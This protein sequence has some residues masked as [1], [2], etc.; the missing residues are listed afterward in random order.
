LKLAVSGHPHL[1]YCTNIHAGETW[2][3][4]RANLERYV[5]AVKA[6]VAPD[7]P[8]G[9]GLRLSARAA[10][11]LAEPAELEALRDFL[12]THGLYVFTINGFPY[13]AFH[14]TRVKEDVYRPDWLEE[15]RVAYTDRLATLL[16]QLLPAQPGLEGSVSTAPGAFKPRVKGDAD[17]ARMADLIIRHVV[18]LHAIR[19]KTG[20]SI[21]LALEP[22]PHCY[23]ET[24]AETVAF[25][26]DYL[27]ASSA[28]ARLSDVIGL[29]RGESEAVL[30]RHLGVCFDACHMAVEFEHPGE[31]LRA[32]QAA[33]IRIGKVQISAGLRVLFEGR[34]PERLAALR[35]FAEGVYL[36]QVV[37]QRG[38][39]LSRYLDLPQALA[40]ADPAAADPREWRVHF[41]VPLF[42]ERLGL[43]LNTQDYLRALLGILRKDVVSQHLEVETYTWDVLPEAYRREDIVTA[44]TRELEWVLERMVSS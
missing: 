8:F 44:V 20:K 9:V 18:T 1:T 29:G 22:E 28:V 2:P 23:L 27:F 17:A 14:G 4:V 16:A 41:H 24:V 39:K 34:D 35:P 7:R 40:E 38:G 42:R 5:V 11:S 37:E 10:E 26:Q 25:F 31:A 32:F 36:H 13:G 3:E 43:F 12:A 21:S 33:G 19:E 6:R 30:R 15:A